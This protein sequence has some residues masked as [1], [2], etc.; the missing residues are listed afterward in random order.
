MAIPPS[1]VKYGIIAPQGPSLI[2]GERSA[3]PV[4]LTLESS[5]FSLDTGFFADLVG[6]ARDDAV[7]VLAA[8][9]DLIDRIHAVDHLVQAQ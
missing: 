8:L 3:R 4:I 6:G 1:S 9:L 2:Q 7:I 5:G